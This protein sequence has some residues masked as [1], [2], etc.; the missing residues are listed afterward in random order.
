MLDCFQELPPEEQKLS[1]RKKDMQKTSRA[2]CK[3]CVFYNTGYGKQNECCVYILSMHERRGCPVGY[4]NKKSTD[5]SVIKFDWQNEYLYTD[6]EKFYN[7]AYR[8][9]QK[10]NKY[11]ND[12]DLDSSI[13]DCNDD[14]NYF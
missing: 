6:R 14:E 2:Y 10:A 5:P 3:D 11:G 1:K 8:K 12:M 13:D 9:Q 4:C 7:S